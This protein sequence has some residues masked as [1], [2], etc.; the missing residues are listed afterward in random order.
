MPLLPQ[1]EQV[2]DGQTIASY[3]SLL[4]QLSNSVCLL[5]THVF[6]SR[7]QLLE[8]GSSRSRESVKA[9]DE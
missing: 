6:L 3:S 7:F 2:D 1:L 9:H 4:P 5:R 8:L